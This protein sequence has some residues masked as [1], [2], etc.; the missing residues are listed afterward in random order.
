MRGKDITLQFDNILADT[1][2]ST[3]RF[4]LN[5]SN[6]EYQIVDTEIRASEGI[7]TL[8]VEK[9][10]DPTVSLTLDYLDFVGD[11]TLGVIESSTGVDLESFTG[12]ALNLSL[13]HI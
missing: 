13:I 3:G 7:V 9:E 6:R 10:L 4:T 5:K 12:F 11:Q 8:T 2:P 1:L